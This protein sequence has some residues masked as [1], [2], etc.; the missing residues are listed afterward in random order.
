M[1]ICGAGRKH[2]NKIF[3]ITSTG[4]QLLP[5]YQ[6]HIA[7]NRPP[8]FP[9]R[10]GAQYFIFIWGPWTG[11][12]SLHM[13]YHFVCPP[14]GAREDR[15][16]SALNSCRIWGR[17]DSV[18]SKASRNGIV[19]IEILLTLILWEDFRKV[20]CRL[21]YD[22]IV[23]LLPWEEEPV[24]TQLLSSGCDIPK[25]IFHPPLYCIIQL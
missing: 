14:C 18:K 15:G 22:I 9:A 10:R 19:R 24:A 12:V 8:L 7:M 23:R 13:F 6:V 25:F 2:A 16:L 20:Y 1:R 17:V 5:W 21:T 3:P 4:T 11:N